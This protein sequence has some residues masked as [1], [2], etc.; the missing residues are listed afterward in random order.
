MTGQERPKLITTVDEDYQTGG[1]GNLEVT[2][3]KCGP[4]NSSFQVLTLL[5]KGGLLGYGCYIAFKVREAAVAAALHASRRCHTVAALQLPLR[6]P[7]HDNHRAAAVRPQ[8]ARERKRVMRC[9]N[10]CM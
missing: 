4:E 1:S 3:T 10:M 9:G 6:A 5:Y 2:H 8:A 7:H